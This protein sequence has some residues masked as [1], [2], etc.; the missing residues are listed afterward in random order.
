M[1]RAIYKG[2]ARVGECQMHSP[3]ERLFGEDVD[4]R[5]SC[6]GACGREAAIVELHDEADPPSECA[7][8]HLPAAARALGPAL[9][10]AVAASDR[11]RW[12]S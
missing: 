10:D 1:A 7:L 2:A 11:G 5:R 8:R 4:A 3:G 9:V 6:H 12:P